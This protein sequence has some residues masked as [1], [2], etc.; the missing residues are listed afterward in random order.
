M[1]RN[2]RTITSLA[3][4]IGVIAG[5]LCNQ[6]FAN[7][8]SAG[9]LVKAVLAGKDIRVINN[10]ALCTKAG[11]TIPGPNIRGSLQPDAYM[12]LQDGTVAF[13]NTHQTI[14]PKNSVVQEY[15]KYRVLPDGKVEFHSFV[16][17]PLDYSILHESQYD[18]SIDKGVSFVW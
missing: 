3:L 12:V 15:L 16:L 1:Q 10:L 9:S 5:G 4:S 8:A 14:N 17:N 11:T 13:S 18:C 7:E 2:Y 6:A